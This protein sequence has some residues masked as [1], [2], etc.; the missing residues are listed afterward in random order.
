MSLAAHVLL[1]LSIY[2]FPCSLKCGVVAVSCPYRAK[3]IEN[4][5]V[6]LSSSRFV[7]WDLTQTSRVI[8]KRASI[9]TGAQF[10]VLMPHA[11]LVTIFMK[12]IGDV[13]DIWAFMIWGASMGWCSKRYLVLLAYGRSWYVN[14]DKVP[15]GVSSSRVATWARHDF[16]ERLNSRVALGC[17]KAPCLRIFMYMGK[18]LFAMFPFVHSA[19]LLEQAGRSLFAEGE[20]RW[21]I[22][23]NWEL[24]QIVTV[25]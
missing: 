2:V 25:R 8:T 4:M 16:E 6:R 17:A 12:T 13:V 5:V 23:W 15:L 21:C 3:S 7:I 22:L 19:S 14:S 24:A 1:E 10:R 18:L 20:T 9:R 11:I